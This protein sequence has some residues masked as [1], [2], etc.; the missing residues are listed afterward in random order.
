MVEVFVLIERKPSGL[1]NLLAW[2][3]MCLAVVSLL[4][5]CRASA[6][7]IV[8][9]V[10][11]GLWYWLFF[12]SK[13]E[14]EYSFFDGDIRFAK[15]INKS[16]RKTLKGYTVE[17]LIQIAPAGDRSVY[18]YENDSTVTVKDYTSGKKDVP[19]Y[20]MII[21][22]NEKNSL[23][24]IKA[25]LDDKYLDAVCFKSASKVIRRPE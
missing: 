6:F 18:K 17:D 21:K 24:L 19:Y 1:R 11:V 22:D 5:M 12:M 13:F 8:A 4:L 2:L 20:D 3:C 10:F 14:Y 23:L 9:A 7:F 25:E 16:R 15:V